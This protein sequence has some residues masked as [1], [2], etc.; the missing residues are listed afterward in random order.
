LRFRKRRERRQDILIAEH[1]RLNM[2]RFFVGSFLGLFLALAAPAVAQNARPPAEGGKLIDNE[3]IRVRELNLKAGQKLPAQSF[4]NTFVYGLTS[5]ALVFAP[6]GRTPYELSFGQGEALW[7]SAQ[8][9]AMQ[10]ETDKEIRVL[11]V[12][13]KQRPPAG[14]AGKGKSKGKSRDKRHESGKSKP[15]AKPAGKTAKPAAKPASQAKS[16][17]K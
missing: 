11:L 16:K 4:P 14:A 2:T 9:A 17:K 8:E 12:E 13:I 5:G 15:A 10:N 6:P 7:L 1:M 3:Q